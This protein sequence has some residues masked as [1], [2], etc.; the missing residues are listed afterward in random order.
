MHVSGHEG[1]DDQPANGGEDNHGPSSAPTAVNERTEQRETTAKGARVRTRYKNTL[2]LAS[3]GEIEKK[4]DPASEMV[5]RVSPANM[6]TWTRAKRPK[7]SRWLKRSWKRLADQGAELRNPTLQRHGFNVGAAQVAVC[8][9]GVILQVGAMTER[10][11]AMA[12][13]AYV[14]IQTEVGLAAQV[15]RNVAAIAGIV[16]AD[17]V[18]GPYDVIAQA[19]SNSMDDL[20]KSGGSQRAS[21]LKAS[22]G[23]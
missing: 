17:D 7:A 23:P 1:A 10:R 14:L 20:G 3:V 2:L 21:R 8:T 13:T 4:S 6:K 19:E 12:V 16:V 9:T 18:T 22:P 15:A 11:P 5:T